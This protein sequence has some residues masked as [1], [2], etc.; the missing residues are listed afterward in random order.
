MI[1]IPQTSNATTNRDARVPLILTV[2]VDS[3]FEPAY[4]ELKIISSDACMKTIYQ[5]KCMLY[6]TYRRAFKV[7]GTETIKIKH[8]LSYLIKLYF[9]MN[10][11]PFHY[12]IGYNYTWLY[13][14]DIAPGHFPLSIRI[15]NN[16]FSFHLS[17]LADVNS[18]NP[19]PL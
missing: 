12:I 4:Q 9:D 13:G 10:G 15:T 16:F 7:K 18:V 3:E 17:I 11:T 5:Y 6:C 8:I 14:A 19:C 1:R 2:A